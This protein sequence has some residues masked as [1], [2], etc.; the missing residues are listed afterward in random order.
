MF[1][2]K[3]HILLILL[4]ACLLASCGRPGS[5]NAVQAAETKAVRVGTAPVVARQVAIYIQSSGS[6]VAD[7][8]SDV[9]PPAAGRI[10][11]T[12]VNVGA[13]VQQGQVIATLDDREAKLRLQQALANQS[14]AEAALRQSQSKIGLGEDAKFDAT[15]VPEV[16]SAMAAYQSAAA[17]AKLALA[18]EKRYANLVATGDVSQSNYEKQ[19][20][21]AETAQAQ[22]DAAKKQ[23]ET[24]LNTARQN[25]QSVGGAEASLAGVRSQLALAQ[26]AVE[27]T[28]VRAP[29]SGYVSDR[30][31]AVGEYV[32]ASS[33]IA[34][35]LRA[36]PIKLHLQLSEAEAARLRVGMSV[37]A[38]VAAYGDRDFAGRVKV[39]GPAVDPTSRAIIVEA[40]FNSP[41]LT[42]RP[43]M[44]AT[45][46]I[47]LPEGQQ[48]LFVPVSSVLTDATTSSSQVFVVESGKARI[49]VVRVGE[50]DNGMLRILSGVTAGAT[51]AT[52]NLKDL[53]DGAVVV[54]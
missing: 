14:Q 27:D 37:A 30:P 43:G 8:K 42:L 44:F 25:Y 46:R 41:D 26:K 54:N 31:I 6:F 48:G 40:E 4:S 49:K 33:K 13:F 35:I 52:S 53:Y 17:Q 38:R 11:T 51:V 28:I 9:A 10:E 22:A 15:I 16:Q 19:R 20:T 45:A 34:T 5:K 36:N 18:D 12:P 47:V 21:Q 2:T 7:E 32:S 50:A 3:H 39:V 24:A 1:I 29:M 23:Y